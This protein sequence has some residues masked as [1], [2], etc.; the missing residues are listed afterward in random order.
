M[1]VPKSKRKIA[2]FEFYA[3]ALKIRTQLTEWLMRDFGA[4]NRI[5]SVSLYAQKARMSEEDAK[6][7]ADIFARHGLGDSVCETYPEWWIHERR[8]ALDRIA[9]EMAE[10][11]ASAFDF[12]ATSIAEW[13][14]R[15]AYQDRAIACVYRLLEETQF[16]VNYLYRTGGVDVAKYMPFVALCEHEI[17]LLKGWR[18][19][20]NASRKSIIEKEEFDRS[21]IRSKLPF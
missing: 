7:M 2:E 3:T 10:C 13:D 17:S 14:A 4:K 20:G 9:C 5:R 12:Y 8:I 11:I 21:K 18:K 19:A 1:S 16:I 6:A 15:R